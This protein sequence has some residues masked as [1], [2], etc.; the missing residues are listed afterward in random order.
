ML[1]QIKTRGG[2]YIEYEQQTLAY[3]NAIEPLVEK[4]DSQR[5]ALF[6]SSFE[7]P[8]RYTCWD[9]G[10]IN[11]PLAIICKQPHVYLQALNKR[12]EVLLTIAALALKTCEDVDILKQTEKVLQVQIKPTDRVFSEEE[13]SL[14]PSIF[15]VIR[16]LLNFFKSPLEPYLGLY[17]AFG[18][19]L[20]FQFESLAQTKVRE[21][22]QREMVL[23][24]PDE[25]YVVNHRKEEA[26]VRR[27]DFQYQGKSTLSLPR[28]GAFKPYEAT[29]KPEKQ[30]IT[31]PVSMPELSMWPRNGLPVAISLKWYPVRFFMRIV[32]NSLRPFF[33]ACAKRTPLP[34]VS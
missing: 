9:I 29:H 6:A 21:A 31:N 13:R 15:T 22:D 5:G 2:L 34:M 4:L 18:Y 33:A 27:Y 3:D 30:A 10:F 12:G 32:P 7:Y 16:V 17:G 8:G 1:Q 25:I 24:L 19:D 26:F 23:Y 11:P 28:D 20:I 14:Q